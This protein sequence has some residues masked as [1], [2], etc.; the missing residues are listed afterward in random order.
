MQQQQQRPKS[1]LLFNFFF[2][3]FLGEVSL[4]L[5]LHR[6][7]IHLVLV[8]CTQTRLV[9][10]FRHYRCKPVT[11]FSR[12]FFFQRTHL[13]NYYICGALR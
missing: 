10:Y 4:S 5:C 6:R 7:G 13:K 2:P 11:Y 9:W 1:F 12:V 3:L 8:E